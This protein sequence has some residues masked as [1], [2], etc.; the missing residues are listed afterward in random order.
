[1]CSGSLPIST[2]KK[3]KFEPYPFLYNWQIID[4]VLGDM[5]NDW[6]AGVCMVSDENIFQ[7]I[8][9]FPVNKLTH[10]NDCTYIYLIHAF[11]RTEES[12]CSQ[13][14]SILFLIFKDFERQFSKRFTFYQ[15]SPF[16]NFSLITF[17]SN[18]DKHS[19]LMVVRNF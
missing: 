7:V 15:L 18:F 3:I 14:I 8:F 12:L 17:D 2:F 11:K 10:L 6:S 19:A 16:K 13:N 9:F 4:A 1:M 5:Q